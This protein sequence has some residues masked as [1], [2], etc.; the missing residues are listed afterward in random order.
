ML[1]GTLHVHVRL[2][3]DHGDTC[4][5]VIGCKPSNDGDVAIRLISFHNE[6]AIVTCVCVWGGILHKMLSYIVA[7]VGGRVKEFW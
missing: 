5:C 1:H 6:V 4:H 2:A 3:V 7:S